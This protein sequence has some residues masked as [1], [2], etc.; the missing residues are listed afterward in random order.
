MYFV[1]FDMIVP[2]SEDI[3]NVELWNIYDIY[4]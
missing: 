4:R 2:D 3:T 1:Y